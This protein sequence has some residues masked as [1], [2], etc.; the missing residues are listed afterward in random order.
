ME[1]DKEE[2]KLKVQTTFT[3]IRNC[4]NEK[5]DELM[6]KIDNKYKEEFF[7][8]NMIKQSELL[9]KKIEKSLEK[10]KLIDKN[11]ENKEEIQ[12]NQFINDCLNIEHNINNINKIKKTIER[13]NYKQKRKIFF[14]NDEEIKQFCS[15]IKKIRFIYH[16]Q[17][18]ESE[19]IEGNDFIRINNWIGGNNQFILKYST[20]RDSC[21]TDIFH[22]KCDN[23]QGSVFIFKVFDGDIIGGYISSK[24]EKKTAFVD[25]NKAFLFNLSRNFIRKNKKS[26][27]NAIKN[28]GD[29]SFFIRFGGSCE[30]LSI[31]GN[32][33]NDRKSHSKY[34]SCNSSNYECDITN[35][36]NK[37]EA[38]DFFMVEKFEV[39]QVV[40]N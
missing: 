23:I 22:E 8:D 27:K 40:S 34:C 16:Y 2:F 5:E 14:E 37:K 32:C 7:D 36:F 11:N 30:I 15:T 19:I 10:G 18:A 3:K 24:I 38:E 35:L 25:D 12:L 28:F 26:F 29:S 6:S 21:N 9:P 4:L 31:S 17:S 39:F 33:I 1:K 13:F 20:K